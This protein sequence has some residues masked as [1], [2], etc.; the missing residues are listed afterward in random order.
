MHQLKTALVFALSCTVI[1]S[2]CPL[3]P[4]QAFPAAPSAA[5]YA[6]PWPKV[7]DRDG[8]HIVVYQPQVKSWRDYRSL[9]ADTAISITQPNAKPILGVISWPT[10]SPTST[11]APCSITTS[12]RVLTATSTKKIPAEIGASGTTAV[13][14]TVDPSTAA[15]QTRNNSQ[16]LAGSNNRP[17]P[18]TRLAARTATDPIPASVAKVGRPIAVYNYSYVESSSSRGDRLLR[19]DGSTPK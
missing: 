5:A 2:A 13:G 1:F 4:L 17:V 18:P 9:I 12:M 15:S 6:F 7:F 8:G 16:N 19:H 14:L 10:P 3:A 11:C